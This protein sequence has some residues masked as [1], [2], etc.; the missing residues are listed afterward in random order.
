MTDTHHDSPSTELKKY[1]WNEN[2]KKYFSLSW[3]FSQFWLRNPFCMTRC[4]EE[5]LWLISLS[6]FTDLL[7]FFFRK[8]DKVNAPHMVAYYT[9]DSSPPL[10]G[11][12]KVQNKTSV[13]AWKRRKKKRRWCSSVQILHLDSSNSKRL[14][15]SMSTFLYSFPLHRF[16]FCFNSHTANTYTSCWSAVPVMLI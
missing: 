10:H 15:F 9:I 12:Y 6:W 8:H 7:S 4:K 3:L 14:I 16:S 11:T 5:L 13:P 1:S 2:G